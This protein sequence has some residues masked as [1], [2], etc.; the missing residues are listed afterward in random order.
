[1][2][3][4]KDCERT[5]TGSEWRRSIKVSMSCHRANWQFNRNRRQSGDDVHE[6]HITRDVAELQCMEEDIGMVVTIIHKLTSYLLD[7]A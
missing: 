2:S 7:A 5:H 6:Y 4:S 3:M 1:M